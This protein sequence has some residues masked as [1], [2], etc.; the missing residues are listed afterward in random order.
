MEEVRLV[1]DINVQPVVNRRQQKAF[2]NYPWTLYRGD[3]NWVPPLRHDQAEMVG[4]LSHPFY[5]ENEAQTFSAYRDGKIC[6]RISAIHNRA[7]VQKFDEPRGYFGFFECVDDQDVAD[8]LLG[9]AK[10]WLAER[11]LTCMRGPMNPG[12]NYTLGTLVEGFDSPPTFMMTYNPS[13]YDRL[14]TGF[15]FHKA[16]DFYAYTATTDLLP[17]ASKRLFPLADQVR[18]RFNVKTRPIDKSRFQQDVEQ[19]MEVYNISM[20]KHWGFLPMSPAEI[21]H[22]A[23]GLRQLIVPELACAIDV[24]D[25][26]V[27]A[28]FVLPDYNPRIKKIDGRLFPF[29]F[30]RLLWNKRSIKKVRIIAANVLP[31]YQLTGVVVVLSKELLIRGTSWGMDQAE[32]SWVA[33]S[34]RQSRGSLEKIGTTLEKTYRVYDWDEQGGQD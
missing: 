20:A 31:E 19:F 9:A 14:I 1:A 33:E 15:G 21:Q 34:N 22:S 28:A 10:Q 12:I 32:Y 26:M 8:A 3:P 13:Y 11:G 16:Q 17:E 7:H 30:I 25:K 6:G 2:L 18:E 4:Y 5:E 24:D 23:K 27:G 29:G